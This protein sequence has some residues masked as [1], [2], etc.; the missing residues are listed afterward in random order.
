MIEIIEELKKRL[1]EVSSTSTNL[2]KAI[3]ALALV[4]F[5]DTEKKR[6]MMI[7]V[8]CIIKL[9]KK[10]KKLLTQYLLYKKSVHIPMQMVKVHLEIVDIIV[11]IHTKNVNFVVM[12]EDVRYN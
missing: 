4:K 6:S 2:I 1:K 3:D 9:K 5:E 10:D 8:K 12:K 11:I 7:F